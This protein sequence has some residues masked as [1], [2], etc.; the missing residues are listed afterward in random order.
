MFKHLI[1]FKPILFNRV[2]YI[3]IESPHENDNPKRMVT[4][5]TNMSQYQGS[6]K[7]I[8]SK[9]EIIVDIGSNILCCGRTFEDFKVG[10]HCFAMEH[11]RLFKDDPNSLAYMEYI[12]TSK[13]MLIGNENFTKLEFKEID[14][15]LDCYTSEYRIIKK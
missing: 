9:D 14:V 4:A 15:Y 13:P 6:I 1:E 3:V 8:K 7:E 2:D 10:D 12:I 5:T 11:L